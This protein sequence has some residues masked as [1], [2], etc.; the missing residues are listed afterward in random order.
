MSPDFSSK[1]LGLVRDLLKNMQPEE[2]YSQFE[3]N[4]F[5]RDK[6]FD[7]D[8]PQEFVDV[9]RKYGFNWSLIIPYLRSGKFEGQ[10]SYTSTVLPALASRE[11]LGRLATFAIDANEGSSGAEKLR[12][13]LVADGFPLNP[14]PAADTTVPV[15]LAQL[16]DQK[17]FRT[18]LAERLSAGPNVSLLFIDCDGFKAVNDNLGHLEGDKCLILAARTMTEAILGKGNLYRYGGDEFAVILPN[19][20]LEEAATTAE[21][22]RKAIDRDS[23][24]RE[25]KVTVSIGVANS[26]TEKTTEADILIHAADS[27]M[28]DAKRK[29]NSVALSNGP[30]N[31]Y[32]PHSR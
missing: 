27:A 25:L 5:W 11:I 17:S 13:S 24:G 3:T 28:Y 4:E 16:P 10:N 30:S 23:P 22:I 32:P 26:R 1:S 7:A 9:A 8:F 6:L 12:S 2:A 15:E 29:K 21:R 19:F 18:D 14:E 20:D 31:F